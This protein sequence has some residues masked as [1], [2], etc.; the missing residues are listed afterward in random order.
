MPC[1]KQKEQQ[2]QKA[3]LHSG[4]A[5]FEVPGGHSY[6]HAEGPEDRLDFF[7]VDLGLGC[8]DQSGSAPLHVSLILPQASPRMFCSLGCS[9]G[10]RKQMQTL[11]ASGGLGPEPPQGHF[12][13]ILLVQAGHRPSLDSRGGE[14]GHRLWVQGGVK[15]Q[16]H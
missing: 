7:G 16:G 9:G 14:V 8:G 6:E 5:D 2:E 3:A 13:F 4:P 12:R 10:A 1:A 11:K 15:N